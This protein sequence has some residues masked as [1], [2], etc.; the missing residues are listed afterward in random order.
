M[1][2][3]VNSDAKLRQIIKAIIHLKT[4]MCQ[5]EIISIIT[6]QNFKEKAPMF[7]NWFFSVYT[8]SPKMTSF[9]QFENIIVL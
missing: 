9:R 8:L 7:D 1:H 4:Q 3:V 6:V 5:A 2:F